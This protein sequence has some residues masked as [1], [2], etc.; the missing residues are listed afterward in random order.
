M[1]EPQ[2]SLITK[3]DQLDNRYREI[4]AQISRP[5]VAGDSAKLIA[6]S[7]EQGKIKAIVSKYREYKKLSS[8][9]DEAQQI[10]ADD[11][12]DPELKGLAEEEVD[13]LEAERNRLLD[14]ITGTLVMADD[15]SID[16][17]ILEIRAGTGGEEAALFARDLYG[18][19]TKYAETRKW[20]VELLDFS[21][22]EK[23]GFREVI[24][25]ING[26]GVWSELGYEGGGHRVQRVPETEAQGRIHTSAATVAVLPEPEE[27]D[28]QINPNDV[29]E[30]VSRAGGPG[31][32]N[33]NKVSSAIRLEHIPTGI[34]VNMREEKSQHKNRA[35]AWRIL[36][37]R[38]YE[39]YQSQKTAE[40]DSKRK[41]MI[42]SGDR[43]QK[44]R[45]YNYPQ[46]RVTDHRINL[47]LYNLDRII[48]GDMERT[49]S[50]TE[51]LRQRAKTEKSLKDPESI[52]IIIV[53]G[54]VGIDKKTYL[55]K[56][57][58]LAGEKGKEVLQCNVGDRMYAEAPDIPPGKIL[59]IPLKRLHSL[60]RSVFKDIIAQSKTAPNLIV[61]TH[62]TFRWRHG[63]FPAVDFDQ[64]RELNTDMYVCLIDGVTALHARLEE[65]HSVEHTLKD[66]IVWR[67]E[68]II[69][70]EMLC[71]GINDKI[72]FYCLARGI[73]NDTIETFYRL[74]FERE[75]KRVYL[76][77]P[78]TAVSD[79]K[80]VQKQINEF[81]RS[82]KLY[83]TC[84]DPGDLEEANLPQIAREAQAAGLDYIEAEAQHKK[85]RLNLRE[86][87]Q[88]ER[89]INSQTYARDF[90]MI[91]Q[92][93]MIISFIPSFADG[94]AA[95]SSGVERE[96]QHAHEAAKDVYVIWQAKQ[97]PSVFV[98]Q[99]AT[100][101]FNTI[102]ETVEYFDGKGYVEKTKL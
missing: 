81:R 34:T 7:K 27:V 6:L 8:Q 37:S 91:D 12:A 88:I 2:N 9:I 10:L 51:K 87:Q 49:D 80:D 60:R 84:F 92:S 43:S 13:K 25:N 85:I 3:L 31:G 72:P 17:V 96:L 74:V 66:L 28:I 41:I 26:P 16:S 53:T 47:S 45:T 64:M 22:T 44:I 101:V 90:L 36:K 20:K 79:M 89:D 77:F 14:D 55:E 30:H 4:D 32:Q 46:N 59:D 15:M 54:M 57:C 65:E 24:F 69:G 23:S 33:V 48:A 99:T 1:T 93:D 40:R 68:E 52:M 58:H 94:R 11:S 38:I 56:V 62:A 42:G 29:L 71:K 78:M 102:I 61:N 98:T 86:V 82:M 95:I 21:P 73:E 75:T 50:R 35:K 19:Y 67:E 76:S 83:F 39:L 97:N 5:E 100:K 70:T 63:L 18:M